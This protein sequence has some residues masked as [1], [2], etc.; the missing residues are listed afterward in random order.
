MIDVEKSNIVSIP[1]L[2]KEGKYHWPQGIYDLLE[3]EPSPED[4]NNNIILNATDEKTR[5]HINEKISNMDKNEI[6]NNE[7]VKI[8]TGTGKTKYLEVN[9]RNV[10]DEDG[11]FIQQSALCRDITPYH[12][13]ESEIKFL[14]GVLQ[15]INTHLGTG[16]FI[17]DSNS[18][19]MIATDSAK[20]IVHIEDRG[21]TPIE[22]QEFRNNIV[23]SEKYL[24]ALHKLYSGEIDK[25]DSIWDY[26]APGHD[27]QKIRVNYQ[28]LIIEDRELWV[29][30]IRDVTSEI[31]RE[32]KII[33]ANKNMEILIN[34]SN[35]RIKNNLNLLLRFISLEKKF[36][37][38]PEHILDNLLGRINSLVVLHEKLSDTENKYD[39]NAVESFRKMTEDLYN[40]YKE[41]SSE[42]SFNFEEHEEFKLPNDK[43]MPVL[44]ILNELVTNTLKYAHSNKIT[45]SEFNSYI[46]K[47][48]N[49][50][51]CFFKDDGSGYPEGF[52]PYKT[53]GLGWVVITSLA[54]QLNGEFEAYN[55][56]GAC[57]KLRFPI[58]D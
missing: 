25:I 30:G 7:S 48:G 34:E 6:I 47:D 31:E 14:T 3:K 35:H 40:I 39:V 1:Y 55:D 9:V 29:A 8:T 45:R 21:N 56:N 33:A 46:K 22:L 57:F 11:C 15:K 37:T 20:Q 2:D 27:L 12:E 19:L 10:Y 24:E 5:A 44:L 54:K 38:K 32:N 36:H 41:L 51:E 13:H 17:W 49:I 43:M 18:D 42:I 23:D 26:K 16:A 58:K 4:E 52:D 50:C 28:Q 53:T